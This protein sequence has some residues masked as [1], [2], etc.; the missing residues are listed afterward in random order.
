[1]KLSEP[2]AKNVWEEIA[3][4]VM[5]IVFAGIFFVG[6]VGTITGGPIGPG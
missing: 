6:L 1:M 3:I 4:V 5:V 2:I